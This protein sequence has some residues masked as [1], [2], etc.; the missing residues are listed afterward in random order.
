MSKIMTDELLPQPTGGNR[1]P[2][3]SLRP[4]QED[5][6]RR[7]DE[8]HGLYK[9]KMKPSEM[10]RGAI[11]AIRVECRSNPDWI[12]QAANS[13]REI[14][15]P[16]WSSQARTVASKKREALIGYGSVLVDDVL[17]REV[18]IVY[19]L[20]NDLAHHGSNSTSL[21][22]S[23]FTISDFERLL[24]DFE[25]IMQDALMRQIDLH[26]EIDKILG[27]NPT[28]IILDNPTT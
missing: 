2:P 3:S 22:F 17:M 24:A 11:F 19:G 21:D 14:L 16:F 10:F 4:E 1:L 8:L 12:A 18:G 25:R 23:T 7:L 26:K 6:C 15:Y 5:L 28:Q 13:L 27:S 20:L 9:L